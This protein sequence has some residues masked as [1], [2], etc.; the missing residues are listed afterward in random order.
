[1]TSTTIFLHDE[2]TLRI[3]FPYSAASVEAI[4]KIDGAR[5]DAASR[6]WRTPLERLD[7]VLS[8][9]GDSAALAPEVVFAASADLPQIAAQPVKPVDPL[10]KAK[11]FVMTCCEAG[12]TLTV[13]GN[14]VIGSGGCWT[15]ILQKEID[16]RADL[17]R[18]LFA[19]GW[20]QPV[21]MG[22]RPAQV[23]DNYDLITDFDRSAAKWEK[24]WR[25]KEAQKEGYK[26][27]AQRRRWHSDKGEQMGM[28][29]QE[30]L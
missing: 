26:A 21:P 4:K 15:P 7:A 5:W 22:I 11:N 30:G 3:S 28:F 1:M 20:Q 2:G 29:E 13:Q 6:T 17:L 23:P 27:A 14:R 16:K 24:N 10:A 18:H 25:A 8:I 19:S 9:F 12:V